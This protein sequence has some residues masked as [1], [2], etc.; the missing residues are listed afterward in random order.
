MRVL[1]YVYA[2]YTGRGPVEKGVALASRDHATV[3]KLCWL[4]LGAVVRLCASFTRKSINTHTHT[5]TR[6]K[7]QTAVQG[8][9]WQFSRAHQST[10]DP[11]TGFSV[12]ASQ[13]WR[14]MK[15][16]GAFGVTSMGVRGRVC[17]KLVA[18]NLARRNVVQPGCRVPQVIDIW[19][20]K[21]QQSRKESHTHTHRM[22]EIS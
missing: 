20:E 21:S 6:C 10:V 8:L 1:F 22:Q 2:W 12:R 3:V 9:R 13:G 16:A 17:V 4:W 15:S 11:T 18:S 5:Q 7:R 19:N 14:G